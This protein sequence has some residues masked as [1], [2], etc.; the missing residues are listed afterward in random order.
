MPPSKAS[1]L[2]VV[3]RWLAAYELGDVERFHALTHPDATAFCLF[4]YDRGEGP[5]FQAGEAAADLTD[6][7]Q[8]ALANG[9]LNAKCSENG[10]VVTCQTVRTSDWGF[11]TDG[12]E[13]TRQ[14]ETTLEF[15][16]EGGLVTRRILTIDVGQT[17]DFA[18]IDAY[19]KWLSEQHPDAY[20][21]LFLFGTILLGTTEQFEFHQQYVTEYQAG[22]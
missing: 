13:P 16:V 15:T 1:P 12:G 8:L 18:A 5:Y 21:E 2:E 4:G 6:S 22:R 3:Q 7:R 9:S 20:D 11:F 10:P 17:F 14:M 19:E